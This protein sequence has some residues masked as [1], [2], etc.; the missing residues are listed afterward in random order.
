MNTDTN[1]PTTACHWPPT[2]ATLEGWRQE[3]KE[4]REQLA[5]LERAIERAE[6]VVPRH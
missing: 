3:A 2:P 1:Y 5:T 6:K 4:L